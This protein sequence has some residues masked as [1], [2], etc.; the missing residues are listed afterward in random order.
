MTS[1]TGYDPYLI[2][3]GTD[4]MGHATKTARARR[5]LTESLIIKLNFKNS[6]TAKDS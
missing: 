2:G 4:L 1:E 6:M 5:L 3:G